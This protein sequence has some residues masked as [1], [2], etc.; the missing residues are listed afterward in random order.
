MNLVI[1]ISIPIHIVGHIR[2]P[3]CQ[4]PAVTERTIRLYKLYRNL[5]HINTNTKLLHYTGA[6]M[7]RTDWPMSRWLYMSW[8]QMATRSS[9]TTM[10][11]R[12]WHNKSYGS[13]YATCIL[14][15]H[16][17]QGAFRICREVGNLYVYLL[18]TGLFSH[19]NEA[20][21]WSTLHTWMHWSQ[22]ALAPGV[23]RPPSDIRYW[24]HFITKLEKSVQHVKDSALIQCKN[25]V[26]SEE[27]KS[28]CSKTIVRSSYLDNGNS[29]FDKTAS[30]YWISPRRANFGTGKISV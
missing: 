15:Y 5:I 4:T 10:L 16:C 24:L 18:L 17:W 29:Y 30:L 3:L 11:I 8:C 19:K 21:S 7:I 14:H 25:V 2:L 9:A 6:L 20:L 28:Y 27:R 26:L 13:Y 23:T 22:Y 12:I 1:C